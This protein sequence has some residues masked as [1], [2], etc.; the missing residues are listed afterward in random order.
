[1]PPKR[2]APTS[3]EASAASAPKT[4]QSKLAKEHNIT[5]AEENEIREAF[6]LFAHKKKGEK[7]GVIPIGDVR[8]AM[9]AL[10]ISPSSDELEEFVTILDPEEEGFAEYES[11]VAICALKFHNRD[12]TSDSHSKE[13][14]EAFSLFT[15]GGGEEKITLAT[16]KRVAKQLREEVDDDMLRDMIL[17]ANGGA[18]V[19]RGVEKVEFEEIMRR[20]G[21]WR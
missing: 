21:V 16:L 18:G 3:A 8:R 6:A 13:L 9:I 20:A 14:D 19:G 17:E 1:M 5:S 12:R 15:Q 2:R 10:D 7:E 4:R 11:F